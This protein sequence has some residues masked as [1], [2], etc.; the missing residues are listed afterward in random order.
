MSGAADTVR[1]AWRR[2][3][4]SGRMLRLALAPLSAI[5]SAA[6]RGRA[7]A[8]R[9]RL[10]GR[11]RLPAAVVSVGNLSVGGT[12]KTPTALW[13]AEALQRVGYVVAILSRGYGGTASRPTLVADP[14]TAPEGVDASLDVDVVGDENLL[15]ARRFSG[16]I[17][18]GKRRAD[19]GQLAAKKLGAE[20]LVL[21]DGFQHLSLRRDFD[22][23]CLRA[24]VPGDDAVLPAGRLREPPSAL[25]RAHAV[26]ITENVPDARLSPRLEARA[27]RLPAY[28]GE[29]RA[30]T[31]VTPD[32]A[33]WRE[34]PM[35]VLAARRALGVA[36]LADPQPFYQTLH[37]WDARLEDFLEFP[38]HHVYTLDDWKKIAHRSRELD[39]VV[40]TEKDMVKL[41][42]FPFAKDKLV[43]LRVSMNVENGEE[44]VRSVVDAIE[45]RRAELAKRRWWWS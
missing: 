38:D 29:I 37:E 9:L 35:G 40:T 43:A 8:Y 25:G 12:G 42:R 11:R 14:A 16:P 39:L 26:L 33:G 1:R 3:G 41:E 18:V 19:A 6:V 7:L 36:G 45:R 17:V 32:P 20:V 13:L 27:S 24:S 28:R 21:D 34:L 30:V 31:L 10:F 5:F 23:V 22:L 44:L 4:T 15:L 2:E